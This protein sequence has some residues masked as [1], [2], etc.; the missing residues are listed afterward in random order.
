M[1]VHRVCRSSQMVT[2]KNAL[3]SLLRIRIVDNLGKARPVFLDDILVKFES[4]KRWTVLQHFLS[5]VRQ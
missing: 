3:K 2:R 4:M 5:H 1:W